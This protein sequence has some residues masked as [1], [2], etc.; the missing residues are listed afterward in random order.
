MKLVPVTA[1]SLAG[2]PGAHI[3]TAEFDCL[4]DDGIL[5]TQRLRQFGVPVELNNTEGTMHGFDIVLDSPIVCA[6]ADRR[7]AFLKW[8]FSSQVLFHS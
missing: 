3:E 4:R 5:Y 7:A 8:A 1:E 6:C 2:M